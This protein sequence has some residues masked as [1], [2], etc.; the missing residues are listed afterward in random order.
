MMHLQT[1]KK[2][3]PLFCFSGLV[4]FFHFFFFCMSRI[5]F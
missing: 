4:T 5:M 3:V 2:A 1:N